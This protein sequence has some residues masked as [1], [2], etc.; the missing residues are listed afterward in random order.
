MTLND[1]GL[2][3]RGTLVAVSFGA[4][5]YLCVVATQGKQQGN[6]AEPSKHL[7]P[8]AAPVLEAFL[9]ISLLSAAVSG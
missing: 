2:L 7:C 5:V 8:G 6:R 3:L 4:I 1:R 9:R